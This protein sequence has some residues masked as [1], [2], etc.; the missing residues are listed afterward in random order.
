MTQPPPPTLNYL[1][2][3]REAEEM[4]S[5]IILQCVHA[6]TAIVHLTKSPRLGN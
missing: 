3:I 5:C 2:V 6:L 1:I 4:I